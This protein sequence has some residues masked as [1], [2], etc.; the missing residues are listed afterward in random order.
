M[1]YFVGDMFLDIFE[2][3][4]ETILQCFIADEEMFDGDECYADK[5]LR[6]WL[7]VY[8]ENERKIILT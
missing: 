3:S 5:D 7:S 2:M 1:A 6:E 8:E 4:T